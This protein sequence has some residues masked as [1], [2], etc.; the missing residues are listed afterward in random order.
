VLRREHVEKRGARWV[1]GDEG[2]SWGPGVEEPSGSVRPV[3]V[4]TMRRQTPIAPSRGRVSRRQGGAGELSGTERLRRL[5]REDQWAVCGLM[6]VGSTMCGIWRHAVQAGAAGFRLD[7]AESAVRCGPGGMA[8]HDGESA[9][10][11]WQGTSR[12]NPGAAE[13]GALAQRPQSNVRTRRKPN[14]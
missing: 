5:P 7:A 9:L 13:A 2:E 3:G 12:R 1:A 4:G 14:I 11:L 8:H 6:K 10:M